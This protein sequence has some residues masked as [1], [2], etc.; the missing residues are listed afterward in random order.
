[1][2]ALLAYSSTKKKDLNSLLVCSILQSQLTKT[3]AHALFINARGTTRMMP[4][5]TKCGT[6]LVLQWHILQH[7]ISSVSCGFLPITVSL[8]PSPPL[9][10]LTPTVIVMII[11]GTLAGSSNLVTDANKCSCWCL[12]VYGN[13]LPFAGLTEN[14]SIVSKCQW[15]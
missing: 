6:Q 9:P 5:G 11:F 14:T 13:V 7:G 1:M 12:P 4:W 8:L 15:Q 2:Y 10:R 3:N